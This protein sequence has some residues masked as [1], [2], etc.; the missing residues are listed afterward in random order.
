MKELNPQLKIG[1]GG[2]VGQQE[3][4][5]LIKNQPMIDFVFG[6]DAI[7]SLPEILT[8]LYFKESNEAKQEVKEED[9]DSKGREASFE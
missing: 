4:E 7:D 6:T 5:K 9:K 1:V 3:K 8:D 2:C